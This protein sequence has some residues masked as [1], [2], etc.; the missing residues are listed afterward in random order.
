VAAKD[1]KIDET[2][3]LSLT[4]ALEN[5]N[6][7]AKKTPAIILDL[8]KAEQ[9]YVDGLKT[10]KTQ[11]TS[12]EDT[13]KKWGS[14]NIKVQGLVSEAAMEY[15]TALGI[16]TNAQRESRIAENEKLESLKKASTN[17]RDTAIL[18]EQQRKIHVATMQD[19]I[20]QHVLEDKGQQ[21]H[22]NIGEKIQGA[23]KGIYHAAELRGSEFAE[24]AGGFMGL[25][26]DSM[27]VLAGGAGVV[28]GAFVA[29]EYVLGQAAVRVQGAANAGFNI[30]ASYGSAAAAGVQYDETIRNLTQGSGF[31]GAKI[32]ELSGVLNQ[33]LGRSIDSSMLGSV[34]LA[35]D[36]GTV[37]LSFGMTADEGVKLGTILGVLTRTDIK[38]THAVFEGLGDASLSLHAPMMAL[39]EPMTILAQMSGRAGA[40]VNDAA[41]SFDTIVSAAE[42]LSNMSGPFSRMFS[43]MKDADKVKAI[44][45]F[46]QSFSK[47]T[48]I[49]WAAFS[50]K[51]GQNFFDKMGEVTNAG[52]GT[53]LGWLNDLAGK[54]GIDKMGTDARGR[55][56]RDLTMGMLMGEGATQEGI[57]VGHMANVARKNGSVFDLT[58]AKT[59]V[60]QKEFDQKQSAAAFLGG[61]G[62]VMQFIANEISKL[63]GLVEKG[64]TVRLGSGSGGGGRT[65]AE[66]GRS[67]YGGAGNRQVGTLQGAR[68]AGAR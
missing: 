40:G 20:K 16:T 53:K 68:M 48:D 61:G 17:A 24:T 26:G 30:G 58:K 67:T 9:K 18:G 62:D 2:V 6:N 59:E 41:G 25:T 35:R 43:T 31:A 12:L 8:A 4:K 64:I 32:M 42:G 1:P 38:G 39:A 45:T 37:G 46:A 50:M 13:I 7:A 57:L 63:V 66:A 15:A 19:N 60:L 28:M 21:Y 14:T 65:G 44:D 49:Q 33:N 56:Q 51:P 11:V 22:G 27:T 29:L 5:Y 3:T 23:L 55:T 10:H 34:Q 47:I 36:L 52:T 54:A